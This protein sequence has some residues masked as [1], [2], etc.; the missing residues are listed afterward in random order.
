MNNYI[1]LIDN[2]I[3]SED[4]KRMIDNMTYNILQPNKTNLDLAIPYTTN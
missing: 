2:M 4:F 1:I 3:I